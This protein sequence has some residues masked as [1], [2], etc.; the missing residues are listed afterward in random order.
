MDELMATEKQIAA[1]RANAKR[2]SGPQTPEGKIRSSMNS[3]KHGLSAKTI[4]ID[5]EDPAEFEELLNDLIRDFNPRPGCEYE[6]VCQLAA[7]FWRL[8]R[9]PRFEASFLRTQ[10]TI[11]YRDPRFEQIIREQTACRSLRQPVTSKHLPKH[12][13]P[14]GKVEPAQEFG[15]IEKEVRA[16][17]EKAFPPEARQPVSSPS[18]N[19]EMLAKVSRYEIALMNSIGRTLNMLLGLQNMRGARA[20]PRRIDSQE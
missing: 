20:E 17:Y 5:G 11:V 9:V 4:V 18:E 3:R 1:N 7:K 15:D 2:S 16:H 13:Q 8:R 12:L 19:Q 14:T 10:Q 6:L